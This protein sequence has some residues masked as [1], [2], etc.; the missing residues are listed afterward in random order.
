MYYNILSREVDH[1]TITNHPNHI[2]TRNIF[3]F[4]LFYSQTVYSSDKNTCFYFWIIFCRFLFSWLILKYIPKTILVLERRTSEDEINNYGGIQ[5]VT[6]SL[7]E[8]VPWPFYL[9]CNT[10][11]VILVIQIG[12]NYLFES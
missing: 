12:L 2:G 1:S 4:N 9:P 7:I 11:L 8:K 10:S 5:I 6:N 3:F